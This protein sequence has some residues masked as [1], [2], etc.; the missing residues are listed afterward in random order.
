MPRLR[1]DQRK[2]QLIDVATKLFSKNGFEATT[3]ASIA[4]AAGIT[5]PI[6][7]RHFKSKAGLFVAIVNDVSQRTMAHWQ[8]IIA[9]T[10]DPAEQIRRIA[11]AIPQHMKE[12]TDAYHVL[13]GALGTSRDRKVIHVLNQHYEEIEK[14]FTQILAG[15]IKAGAFRKDLN[16]RAAAWQLTFSGIG[17]AMIALNLGGPDRATIEDVIRSIIRGF[18]A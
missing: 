7:Y 4:A 10:T 18:S 13:H 2:Q 17:Y 8:S 12:L 16:P 9:G 3:T 1:A 5:E 14:F 11:L 6:L 15:G